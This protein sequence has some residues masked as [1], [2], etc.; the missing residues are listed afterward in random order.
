MSQF[1]GCLCTARRI[2]MLLKRKISWCVGMRYS[3]L[4]SFINW[5]EPLSS[6]SS[7]SPSSSSFFQNCYHQQHTYTLHINNDTSPVHLK[8]AFD[9]PAVPPQPRPDCCVQSDIHE[10]LAHHPEVLGADPVGVCG[11]QVMHARKAVGRYGFSF[12]A[13]GFVK[14]ANQPTN[15]PTTQ[16]KSTDNRTDAF[17]SDPPKICFLTSRPVS[18]SASPA[19]ASSPPPA[20]AVSCCV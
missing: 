11:R 5:I 14:S 17:P 8:R 4:L 13:W 7:S 16:S 10:A 9:L 19:A 12:Y 1:L 18:G 20:A 6:S 15:Q 3:F 2:E